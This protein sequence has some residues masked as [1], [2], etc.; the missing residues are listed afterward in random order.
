MLT[1]EGEE[2]QVLTERGKLSND[3]TDFINVDFHL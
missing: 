1:N 3:F 2:I